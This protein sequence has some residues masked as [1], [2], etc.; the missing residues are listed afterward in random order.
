MEEKSIS[1][2]VRRNEDLYQSGTTTISRHVSFSLKDTIDRIEAYLF[3][4]HTS[5]ET[6]SLGREKPFFNISMAVRNIWYRATDK[7]RANIRIRPT[8]TEHTIAALLATVKLQD[9]MR[10][11]NFG[12]FLNDWGRTLATYGSAIVEFVRKDGRLIPSVLPWNRTIVDAVRLDNDVLIKKL[13][14]TPAQ[15]MQNK[16]YDRDLVDKLI[17]AKP[18]RHDM[19]R[20]SID[21]KA[22]FIEVYEVHGVLPLS[23]LKKAQ[24]KEPSKEDD[25]IFVQQVHHVS[26]HATKEAGKQGYDEYTLYAGK[27]ENPHMITHLIEEEG[28]I[29]SIGAIENLFDAQWMVNHS[30]KLIKDALDLASKAFFQT[31]DQ[32]FIGRNAFSAIETGD[33]FIHEPN[34]PITPVN[35]QQV[36][37]SALQAFGREWQVLGQTV[38]STPDAMRGETPPSGTAWHTVELMTQQSSSL[39]E[40]MS[41]N[42]DLYIEEMLRRFVIPFLKTQLDTDEEVIATLESEQLTKIDSMY[43]PNKAIRD[44]NSSAV[45]QIIAGSTPSPYDKQLGEQAVREQLGKQGNERAFKPMVMRDGVEVPCTWKEVLKDL[46]WDVEYVSNESSN[47]KDA[48]DTLN[49]A[50]KTLVMLQGREMS[51]QEKF[52]FNKILEK[53]GEISPLQ[54]A[55]IQSAPPMP[56][57]LPAQV[58][59][60]GGGTAMAPQMPAGITQ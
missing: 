11:E 25:D 27:E 17:D 19:S 45:E 57:Q 52:V 8:K 16:L 9:W 42:K 7:D 40:L 46:E 32:N 33:F 24:G 44:Y 58:G 21:T 59:A 54:L 6:D 47:T 56:P 1:E 41:E 22:D 4:K 55:Q 12:R 10:R 43:I 35:N 30:Q 28:R 2:I 51:P 14:F 34:M 15:L 38:S 31:A 18:I 23:T 3:S 36:N 49:T 48:L 53:T 50:F 39:F 60:G 20:Q 5:G 26:F 29:L 13:Q 37:I